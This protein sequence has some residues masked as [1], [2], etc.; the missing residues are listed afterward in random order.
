M[1]L[2]INL[3]FYAKFKFKETQNK[4]QNYGF[5]IFQKFKHF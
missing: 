5:K 3:G 2:R 4:A 1:L